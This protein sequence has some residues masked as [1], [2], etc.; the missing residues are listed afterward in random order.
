MQ[1]TQHTYKKKHNATKK[2]TCLNENPAGEVTREDFLAVSFFFRYK[3]K[4]MYYEIHNREEQSAKSVVLILMKEDVCY[5]CTSLW[6]SEAK[7]CLV[8][9]KT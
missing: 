4:G 2:Q 5:S 6:L 7:V 3:L 1:Q 8:V 9:C